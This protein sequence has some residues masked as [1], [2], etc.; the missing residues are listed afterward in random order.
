MRSLNSLELIATGVAVNAQGEMRNMLQ[1]FPQSNWP[2][3]DRP[4]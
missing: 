4:F 1:E 2:Y 3:L